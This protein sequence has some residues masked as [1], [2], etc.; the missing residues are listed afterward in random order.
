MRYTCDK[1]SEEGDS[2]FLSL[3]DFIYDEVNWLHGN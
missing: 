3:K 1:K 2:P